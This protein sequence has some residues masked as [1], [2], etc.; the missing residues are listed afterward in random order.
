VATAIGCGTEVA[1]PPRIVV[2]DIHV[3]SSFSQD[4]P[5]RPGRSPAKTKTR[6]IFGLLVHF[7]PALAGEI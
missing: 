4:K 1:L 6:I 2:P 5:G 7:R 3:A